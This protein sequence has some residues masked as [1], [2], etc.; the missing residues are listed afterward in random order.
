MPRTLLGVQDLSQILDTFLTN[1]PSYH[2]SHMMQ[3]FRTMR[4]FGFR[5]RELKNIPDWEYVSQEEILAKTSKGSAPRLLKVDDCEPF[6]LQSI[7]S[8]ENQ[9]YRM[10]YSTYQRVFTEYTPALYFEVDDGPISLHLFRHAYIK[11]LDASGNSIASI[12]NKTGI[13]SDTI[14]NNYINSNIYK[15]TS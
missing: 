7:G 5:I 10:S 4:T 9:L 2:A 11:E 15:I 8:T 3:L 1:V 6:L 13:V 14:V 12:R